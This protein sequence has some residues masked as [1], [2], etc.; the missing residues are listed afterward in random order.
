[1]G[2]G[3]SEKPGT[4][5]LKNLQQIK[6]SQKKKSRSGKW[7]RE[8]RLNPLLPSGEDKGGYVFMEEMLDLAPFAKV[9]ATGPEDPLENKY[10]FNCM[11][12]RRNSSTKTRGLYELKRHF[13]RECH[14]RADQQIK[15]KYCPGKVRGR[16]GRVLYGSKLEA[17]RGF[18]ME[19]D[20]PDLDIKRPIYYDVLEGQPL[21]SR[22]KSLVFGFKSIC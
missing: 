8:G 18:Y 14:F 17:E 22:L 15:Q 3:S 13:Q 10:C 4:D 12:Y 7:S 16:D 1:M 6:S 9:F 5:S 2:I 19:L 20:V 21:L 11:L